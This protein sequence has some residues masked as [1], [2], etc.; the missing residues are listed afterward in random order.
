MQKPKKKQSGKFNKGIVT[1]LDV[2]GWKGLW[3]SNKEAVTH[4]RDIVSFTRKRAKE[5]IMK[6]DEQKMYAIKI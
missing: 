4:L 1:F 6:K 2:L 3:Q 5:L